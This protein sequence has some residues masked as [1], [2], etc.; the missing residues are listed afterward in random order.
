MTKKEFLYECYRLERAIAFAKKLH[1]PLVA[2]AREREL[3]KL[4]KEYLNQN[5]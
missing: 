4:E 5:E 1:C 2:A 3:R